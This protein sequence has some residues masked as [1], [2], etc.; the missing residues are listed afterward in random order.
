LI[1]GDNYAGAS[2]IKELKRSADLEIHVAHQF[3]PDSPDDRLT[4]HTGSSSRDYP[5]LF[6]TVKPSLVIN[7]L[8]AVHFDVQKEI[9][10]AAVEKGVPRFVLSEYGHDTQNKQLQE[11]LPPYKERARTIE[12]VQQLSKDGKIEWVAVA[13]G[14]VLDRGILNGNLGFDI[15]WQ[16]AAL[17]GNDNVPFPGSSAQW[18]GK[19]MAAVIKHWDEVKNQY[20]YV[21]GL[22]PNSRDIVK[23]LEK[24]RNKDFAVSRDDVK[25]Y[26]R[27]AHRR[28]KQGFPDAGMFL[29]ERSVLYDEDLGNVRPF[30]NNDAKEK[31]G[32]QAEQLEDIIKAVMHD[33]D[34]HGGQGGCGCD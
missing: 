3:G 34:H 9:I 20:L 16:S 5:Q 21:A 14:T 15:K 24:A 13:T 17:A 33:Y 27:E 19:V 8:T 7:T 22:T 1:L 31:L 6:S 32:L 4:Y 12:Y 11:R 2:I 10:D 30:Q 26:V 25:G 28:M 23:S 18:D 29:M